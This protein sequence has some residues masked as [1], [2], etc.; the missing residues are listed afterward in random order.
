MTNIIIIIESYPSRLDM[1]KTEVFENLRKKLM[2]G[3]VF[4]LTCTKIHKNLVI[5]QGE[6]SARPLKSCKNIGIRPDIRHKNLR[7]CN[8]QAPEASIIQ[9]FLVL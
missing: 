3:L 6:V 7:M 2:R 8:K 4:E 1:F 5:Y 9:C